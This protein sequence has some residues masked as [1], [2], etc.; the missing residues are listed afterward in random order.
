MVV[1]IAMKLEARFVDG[2]TARVA[3]RAGTL[4]D[5]RMNQELSEILKQFRLCAMETE[6][7]L[8][9]VPALEIV[10]GND[11]SV[12]I[13]WHLADRR[14]GFNIEPDQGQSG[15]FYAFSRDSG[16]H[17]APVRWRAST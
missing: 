7:D 16:G 10:A 3:A 11:G 17:A 14:L 6:V 1:E 9:G 2:I 15:W 8:S 13:E 4:P 5:S 12:L